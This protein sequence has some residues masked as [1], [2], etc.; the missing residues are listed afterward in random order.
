MIVVYHGVCYRTPTR[1]IR[2]WCKL[3]TK[4]L[5]H[6]V[7]EEKQSLL[8]GLNQ[9]VIRRNLMAIPN[10]FYE[11]GY[12]VLS[13]I[14]SVDVAKEMLLHFVGS[15]DGER[16]PLLK[17]TLDRTY[18][19]K[20][21]AIPVCEDIVSTGFQA[22][23]YDMGMPFS[24]SQPQALYTISALYKPA[25]SEPN[26]L[27]KT[28]VAS[29]AKLLNQVS[30]GKRDE[31]A[32]RLEAYASNHGDG[33][34]QPKPHNTQRLAIFA[35]V[36]DALR[37]ETRL[38][39]KIDTMIGQCFDYDKNPD[40]VYGLEQEYAFFKQARLDLA[41]VE[42]Q[43]SLLPGQMLVFDNMTC[44]HGRVG[45]RQKRELMHFLFG[46]EQA[47]ASEID[48]YKQWLIEQAV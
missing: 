5:M 41:A 23:H 32:S 14:P 21:D 36:I 29:I 30:L 34:V 40:G 19:A 31:L 43:I 47:T 4:S 35:R 28:R 39:D 11:D 9:K 24:A 25:G 2:C 16:A 37:G 46:V 48:A 42:K 15:I 8:F 17:S 13:G 33:W 27:A 3:V 44:V 22:M 20:Q 10:A 1:D 6:T 45:R 7:V 26:P 12:V 38:A 18:L